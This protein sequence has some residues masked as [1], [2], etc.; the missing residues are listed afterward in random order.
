MQEANFL[1]DHETIKELSA[2]I[3]QRIFQQEAEPQCVQVLH[4]SLSN[5]RV[6]CMFIT[7]TGQILVKRMCLYAVMG[8]RTRGIHS[9]C[10]CAS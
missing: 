5:C 2:E 3:G 10:M 9:C 8:G 4:S 7:D 6:Q 1:V